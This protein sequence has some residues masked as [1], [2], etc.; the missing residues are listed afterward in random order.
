[1]VFNRGLLLTATGNCSC[2]VL[3]YIYDLLKLTTGSC[4]QI[5]DAHTSADDLA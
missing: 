5:S 2:L 1:M 3:F 4:N